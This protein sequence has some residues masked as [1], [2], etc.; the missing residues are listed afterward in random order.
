MA[1]VSLAEDTRQHLLLLNL[2]HVCHEHKS[3]QAPLQQGN[4]SSSPVCQARPGQH[5]G[6]ECSLSG[7]QLLLEEVKPLRLMALNPVHRRFCF[8][9][10]FLLQL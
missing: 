9:L 6:L 5:E 8:E 2:E 10:L 3:Q 1:F 4:I 7:L